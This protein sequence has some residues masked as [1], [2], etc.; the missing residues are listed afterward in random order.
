[1]AEIPHVQTPV[2]N[3]ARSLGW[4]ARRMQYIGR[5][6]CP[7]SWFF[8]GGRVIVIEFKDLGEPPKLHQVREIKRLRE[9][10]IAVHVI[11]TPEAGYALFD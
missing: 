7:D 6:G 1:M 11:D 4:R 5:H 2:T 10:G 9:S 3:Y 8:K